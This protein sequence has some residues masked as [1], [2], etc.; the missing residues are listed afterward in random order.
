MPAAHALLQ[1][2]ED[3]ERATAGLTPA[4]IWTTPSGAPSIGFHIQHVTG[5]TDRLL[6]YARGERLDAA[7]RAALAAESGDDRP[8]LGALLAGLG[9]AIDAALA[10]IRA[11]PAD[12]LTAP[13]TVGRA[14]L[15]TTVI[16]LLFHSGEHAQRHAGQIVTIARI[17]RSI[18]GRGAKT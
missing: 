4:Q 7:Q 12:S 3:I 9:L 10:Q 16:G 6:T 5:S 2:R 13:R 8:A 1:T 15:P 18:D 11:T 14:A 17:V